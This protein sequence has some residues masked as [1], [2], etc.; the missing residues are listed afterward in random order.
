MSRRPV[1]SRPGHHGQFDAAPADVGAAFSFGYPEK[2]TVVTLGL[3]W[4]FFTV[5]AFSITSFAMGCIWLLKTVM[6][7]TAGS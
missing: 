4:G 3:A 6:I 1:I 2:L 7:L 5:L